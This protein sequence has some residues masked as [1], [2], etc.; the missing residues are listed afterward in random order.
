MAST[1]LATIPKTMRIPRSE[2]AD[3]QTAI[4]KFG[5]T[6]K[7]E[8]DLI[9][10]AKMIRTCDTAELEILR[11]YAYSERKFESNKQK[12]IASAS[13]VTNGLSLT[14]KNKSYQEFELKDNDM[15]LITH[16]SYTFSDKLNFFDSEFYGNKEAVMMAFSLLSDV[17][18]LEDVKPEV[19]SMAIQTAVKSSEKRKM[20]KFGKLCV[21]PECGFNHLCGF[22]GKPSGCKFS[23]SCKYCHSV[24]EDAKVSEERKKLPKKQ[25]YGNSKERVDARRTA[26][27]VAAPA[28]A[29]AVVAAAAPA[30]AP[31][32]A[33]PQQRA[34]PAVAT[35]A[36]ENGYK[37][38]QMCTH[39]AGKD[40]PNLKK[41]LCSRPHPQ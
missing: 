34:L 26:A 37:S 17:L 36:L 40:C 28:A 18:S 38:N 6:V 8:A 1:D 10:Y 4:Q 22:I 27:P 14:Y 30:A 20:C 12:A 13:D 15:A 39:P 29:P 24:E 9:V 35:P 2:M 19:A 5:S 16:P 31:A 41:G 7:T 11:G 33:P 21:N 32:V 25:F 23:N 3:V